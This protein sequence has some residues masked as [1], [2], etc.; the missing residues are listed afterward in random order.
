ML[1]D[2]SITM[3]LTPMP[4]G[5]TR[6][7]FFDLAACRLLFA[8]MAF[9]HDLK[10]HG[11]R[12]ASA[13]YVAH[14]QDLLAAST[15]LMHELKRSRL[16]VP[17]LEPSLAEWMESQETRARDAR[18]AAIHKLRPNPDEPGGGAR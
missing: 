9:E 5:I 7:Q 6:E 8:S 13:L 18:Q 12:N 1:E 14:A 4:E 10:L 15:I 3:R 2:I 16:P 17:L 11:E